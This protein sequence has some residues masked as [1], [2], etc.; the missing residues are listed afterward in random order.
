MAYSRNKK[1]KTKKRKEET[2]MFKIKINNS[3]GI[4]KTI[5]GKHIHEAFT[6][7][8]LNMDEWFIISIER[9]GE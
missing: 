6:N 9:I 3:N 2:K 5:E 1:Y 8:N 7:A 4:F